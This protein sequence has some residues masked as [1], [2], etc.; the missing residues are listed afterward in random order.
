[1]DGHEGGPN[2]HIVHPIIEVL[3]NTSLKSTAFFCKLQKRASRHL[4]RFANYQY[5]FTE[6]LHIKWSVDSSSM[7]QEVQVGSDNRLILWRFFFN[8]DVSCYQTNQNTKF[9]SW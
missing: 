3:L 4:L 5:R 7:P 9:G 8:S 1:M 6:N 2:V